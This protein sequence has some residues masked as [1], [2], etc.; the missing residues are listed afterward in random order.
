MNVSTTIKSFSEGQKRDLSYK[1]N[2]DDERKKAREGSLNV[3]LSKD[4]MGTFEQ[5]MDPHVVLVL[6]AA[7]G[8]IWKK[9]A[10]TFLR[11]LPQRKKLRLKALGR[12]RKLMNP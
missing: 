6:Y 7:A 8:K 3:S 4:D 10:T 9:R 12:W 2:E 5:G 11:F 1:S